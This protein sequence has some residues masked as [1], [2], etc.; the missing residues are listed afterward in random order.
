M[1]AISAAVAHHRAR[2]AALTRA[3]RNGERPPDDADLIDAR[4][5]LTA[6]RLEE[7]V[8]RVLATAPRP[9][10]EQLQHIATILLSGGA[11]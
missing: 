3:I 2:T 6:L 4:Q 7:H 5:N 8:R 10:D 9:S 1:A 11:A